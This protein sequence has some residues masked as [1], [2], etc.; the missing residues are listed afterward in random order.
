MRDLLRKEKGQSIVAIVFVMVLALAFGVSVAVRV[1]SQFKSLTSFD[2]SYRASAA[3]EAA[4]ERFLVM[5]T[6]TLEDYILF[7]TCGADCHIEI[8]GDD[9]VVAIA[10][11]TLSF[12]G[13]TADPFPISLY[14]YQ[15]TQ[16]NLVDYPDNTGVTVC[17]DS[18]PAGELPSVFAT[19]VYGPDDAYAT[20]AYAYNSI[21]SSHADNNFDDAAANYGYAH[22]FTVSG[23]SDPVV[24]RLKSIY[25]TIDAFVVPEGGANVPSQ[26]ILIESVGQVAGVQRKVSVVKSPP[27]LPLPFDYVLYQ[28]STTQPLSN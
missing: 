8:T 2:S 18:P 20:Q 28:K 21:G 3:A 17:W 15:A 7:G 5:P 22:C 6:E 13:E 16:V 10:D 1:I 27:Y 26:G 14:T 4:I 19:F 11:V 24:L 23:E 25:N 12:V 9:G